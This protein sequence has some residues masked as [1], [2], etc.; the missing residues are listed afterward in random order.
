MLHLAS[1]SIAVGRNKNRFVRV[2]EPHKAPTVFFAT[3]PQRENCGAMWQDNSVNSV[4]DVAKPN[5]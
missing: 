3:F 2:R 5:I 1:V 4:A